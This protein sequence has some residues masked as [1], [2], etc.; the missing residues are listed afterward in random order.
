LP[1][2]RSA[3]AKP[4]PAISSQRAASGAL[5]ALPARKQIDGIAHRSQRA[6]QFVDDERQVIGSLH[7]CPHLENA[8]APRPEPKGRCERGKNCTEARQ[9]QPRGNGPEESVERRDRMDV[10]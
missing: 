9:R 2:T 8:S 5:P 1:R 10:W 3:R 6:A 4:R 7:C